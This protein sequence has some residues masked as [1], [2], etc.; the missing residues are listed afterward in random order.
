MNLIPEH[1]YKAFYARDPRYDGVFFTGVTSTGVYCRPVCR[2]RKPKR[3]NCVFFDSAALAEQAAFRPCLLC[4]PE[5]APGLSPNHR[6]GDHG[7][8]HELGERQQRRLTK[9]S[10]GATPKQLERTQ[11]LL[12][13]KQLLTDTHLP[14]TD[15][16]FAAGFGSVRRFNDLVKKHYNLTPSALRKHKSA[17]TQN[18]DWIN[19]TLGYRPPYRW[20][21]LLNFLRT[22]MIPGVENI[23]ES[24]FSRSL[25]YKNTDDASDTNKITG[26][27]KVTN[28]EKKNQLNIAVSSS[29]LKH[30]AKVLSQAELVFDTRAQPELIAE[31]LMA[32]GIPGDFAKN[33]MGL[34]VPGS[35]AGFELAVRAI[36][37]QQ[38][39]V[40]A[41][42][43]L[44]RRFCDRFCQPY[45]GL[46]PELS[47]LPVSPDTIAGATVDEIASLGIIAR[48]A[49]AI[50]DVAQLVCSEQLRLE[51]GANATKVI[52]QLQTIK[53]IGPWTANYIALRSLAW[54]DAFPK[55]DVVLRKALGNVSAKQADTQS[56]PWQPWRSY[57]CLYL[58]K[59][60]MDDN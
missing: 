51:P 2:A 53:G 52:E 27:I 21:E 35:F 40:K 19:L 34:R 56:L 57:A 13:A 49:Q 25:V 20:T 6:N 37:G 58:W 24:S 59:T 43:T 48:R 18:N 23:T 41:A 36:L 32:G 55:E 10:V 8:Y 9:S 17:P 1:Y 54:P 5:L 33:G 29:L 50:I 42:I 47:R 3:Q 44:S 60:S 12:L 46:Q 26:E 11:K 14:I 39:T 4:R 22:R 31:N 15:V 28:N 45:Q 7:H 16:A 30:L 38:I